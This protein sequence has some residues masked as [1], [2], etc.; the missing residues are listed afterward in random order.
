MV[1]SRWQQPRHHAELKSFHAVR[2]Q[3]CFVTQSA[4]QCGDI[5]GQFLQLTISDM[6]IYEVNFYSSQYP[7]WRYTRSVFT[8]HNIRR[9]DIRGQFLQFTISDVAI[10][11]VGFYSSQYPMGRYTRSV[12][13]VHNIR[14]GDIRGRFIQLPRCNVTIYEFSF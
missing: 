2:S 4:L 9:G 11:E 12:F 13:T 5:R 1:I 10:Y 14:W 6:A 7:T 8:V 3:F